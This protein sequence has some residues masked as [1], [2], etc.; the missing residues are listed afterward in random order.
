[1]IY[2]LYGEQYPT[3]KKQLK[4]L[5][6]TLLPN[7]EDDFNYVSISSRNVLVQDIVSECNKP[8]M[9]SDKKVVVVLQPYYLT[10]SKD[11]C[12]LEKQQDYDCLKK[13]IENP[14]KYVDLIFV[15]EGCNLSLK[16]EI[17]KAIKKHGKVTEVPSLTM[18]QFQEV[19][20]QYFLKNKVEID[21]D[22]LDE[23]VFRC[24]NDLSKFTMDA[25]K[26]CLYSSH[27]KLED[28][29][30]LCALKPEQ[31]AFAIQENLIK[32]NVS[33]A[34]KI[35]YDLRIMK[36]E[37][38]RLIAL[39]ASQFRILTR[40]GYLYSKHENKDSIAKEMQIHPYRVQL[41]I[42]NLNYIPLNRSMKVLD[43]LYDLDYKIK[44]GQIDPYYGFELFLL[45]F[46]DIK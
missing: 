30:S 18:G 8:A 39:I 41:A 44:S 24:G 4:K 12:D 27:I 28:V 31:N 10:N 13:Y 5:K 46:N 34:L 9:F 25:A 3:I 32:G 33:K 17:Y 43:S 19:A 14:S 15:V 45:N 16:S 36:E 11:K 6:E 26:L 1:M 38:V 40:V 2:L 42:Q 21:K 35:Y 29:E 23:L 7:G 20:G 22:A 37:P